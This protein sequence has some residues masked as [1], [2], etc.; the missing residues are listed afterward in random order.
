ML[1]LVFVLGLA[2]CS[3][4]DEHPAAKPEVLVLSSPADSTLKVVNAWARPTVA[5][6][7]ATGAY[8]KI[9]SSKEGKIVGVTSTVAEVSEIHE[10]KMEGDVMRMRAVE[11]IPVKAGSTVELAPGGYHVM[12]MGLNEAVSEGKPFEV[13]L[14]FEGA[15]GSKAE[16][17]VTVI[18]GKDSA[19]AAGMK[20]DAQSNHH[21]H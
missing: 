16:I 9:T 4:Q 20:G 19:G 8:M 2:A 10:M 13:K 5:E 3:K 6:Q 18:P 11:N 15:D 7:M 12:L 21:K 1:A 17:P 14:Q